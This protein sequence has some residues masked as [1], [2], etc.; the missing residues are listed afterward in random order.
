MTGM[1]NFTMQK[2][3]VFKIIFDRISTAGPPRLL[4]CLGLNFQHRV[5][6]GRTIE[7]EFVV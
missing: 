5:A 3:S 1:P 6:R 4:S 7:G 2:F